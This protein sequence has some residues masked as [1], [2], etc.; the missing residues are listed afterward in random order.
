MIRNDLISIELKR[1]S[2]IKSAH[3]NTKTSL[4]LSNRFEFLLSWYGEIIIL[5]HGQFD[6]YKM[7]DLAHIFRLKQLLQLTLFG[8]YDCYETAHLF[9][10][11][12]HQSETFESFMLII[13][14][15][16]ELEKWQLSM[17]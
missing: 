6:Y 16:L 8:V 12:I 14:I 7:Y 15:I 3:L 2:I 9:F 4:K 11:S 1:I 17:I 5:A 10:D 13:F